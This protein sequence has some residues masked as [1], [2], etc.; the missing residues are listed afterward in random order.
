MAYNEY[1]GKDQAWLEKMLDQAHQEDGSGMSAI[2]GGIDGV[3]FANI[4]TSGP[5]SRIAKLYRA[6]NKLDPVKYSINE[7]TAPTRT[8]S[9]YRGAN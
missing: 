4:M 8:V 7:I 5:N 1:I 3:T 6:L 2:S 9:S